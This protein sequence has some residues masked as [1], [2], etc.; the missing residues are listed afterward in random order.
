M[1]SDI[2]LKPSDFPL[3]VD[4]ILSIFP[5][6]EEAKDYYFIP[7]EGKKNPSGRLYSRY[8]NCRSKRVKSSQ[9]SCTTI[10]NE[11]PFVEDEVDMSI[12]EAM[13]TSLSRDSSDWNLVKEK[14][15]KTFSLRQKELKL[16]SNDEF[17][18]S[19]PKFCDARAPE[20]IEIDFDF[21]YP[22]KKHLLLSKWENFKKN[23]KNYYEINIHNESC[24]KRFSLLKTNS[25][26]GKDSEDF[27]LTILLNSVIPPVS[28]FKDKRGSNKRKVTI[29]DAQES[30]ILRL[31]LITNYKEKIEELVN[32]YYNIKLTVQP[33]IIVV[34]EDDI[35]LNSFFVYL[36]KTLFKFDSFIEAFDNCFKIFQVLSLSYPLGCQ[37]SWIF[38][39]K[40]FYNINTPF[41]IKSPNI[42]ALLSFLNS[43][44]KQN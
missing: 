37:P 34:G 12:S 22:N 39:Q 2:N 27:L 9:S 8:A 42:T 28:R 1:C 43:A 33:F 41:D 20:L 17:F 29:S 30:F 15:K 3:I 14:W 24:R 25:E 40:Y 21:L 16:M 35:N 36:D 19:W 23:I 44:N 6:E 26:I 7:R 4:Q 31:P 11:T 13:K 32:K 10:T 38:I 5:N 18:K